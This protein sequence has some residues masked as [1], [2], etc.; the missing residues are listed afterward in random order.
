MVKVLARLAP[1]WNVAGI[2]WE[3]AQVPQSGFFM[4]ARREGTGS[5]GETRSILAFWTGGMLET[6]A[7][8]QSTEFKRRNQEMVPALDWLIKNPG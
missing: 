3:G 7:E 1:G 5:V 8:D 2:G 4:S 6:Y